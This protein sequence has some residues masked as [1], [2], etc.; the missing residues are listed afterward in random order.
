MDRNITVR[1]YK[2]GDADGIN[3]MFMKYLSFPDLARRFFFL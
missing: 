2:R 1:L 3:S